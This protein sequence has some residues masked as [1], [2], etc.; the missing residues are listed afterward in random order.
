M[1]TTII[2]LLWIILPIAGTFLFYKFKP[3]TYESLLLHKKEAR[4]LAVQFIKRYSGIDVSDWDFYAMYWYD[5]NTVNM[6][7]HLGLLNKVRHI[8]YH[9][10]LVESWRIRFVRENRSVIIGINS[11]GEITFY[12][13]NLSKKEM[14][15]H[16]GAFSSPEQ[17]KKELAVS[18][19]GL[20]ATSQFTGAGRKEEDLENIETY[21]YIAESQPVRMKITVEIHNGQIFYIGSEQEILTEDIETAVKKEQMES[22][23][24]MTGVLASCLAVI[25]AIIILINLRQNAGI[26]ASILLGAVLF[27]CNIITI[28][29]DIQLSIV[30]T[31]DSRLSIKTV[32][33]L[34][35]LSAILAGLATGFVVYICSLAGHSLSNVLQIAFFDNAVW[36]FFVGLNVGIGCLGFFSAIFSWLEEKN[37]LRISPELSNRT[38]YLSGFTFKQGLSIGLQSSIAEETVYRLLIIPTIWWLSGNWALAIIISSILWAIMHQGTGF[39]PRWIRWIQLVV[40]GI[41]LG[42]FF[43]QFGFLSSLT[44]HFIYNFILVMKPLWDYTFQKKLKASETFKQPSV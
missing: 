33:A 21:W 22:T 19:N 23:L 32:Y 31:Y 34:G 27:F 25:A 17:L 3:K 5:R 44:I 36:Q 6:L 15:K 7:H 4:E 13:A 26:T 35:I 38:I 20:W 29:E 39:H 11:N 2:H 43:I 41:I 10:G 30:N 40:F 16:K 1:M 12:T 24:N 14:A 9:W 8:L 18:D 42:F 37:W 28:K